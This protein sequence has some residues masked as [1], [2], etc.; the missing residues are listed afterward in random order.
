MVYSKSNHLLYAGCGDNN[1]YVI[2]LEDGK[3]VRNLQG[4]TDYIHG[5]SLMYVLYKY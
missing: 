3:I 4:H 1:I 2:S 5:L